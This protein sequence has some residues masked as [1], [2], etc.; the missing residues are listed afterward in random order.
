MRLAWRPRPDAVTLTP[1]SPTIVAMS[2]LAANDKR[3]ARSSRNTHGGE[4]AA[5]I[6]RL[7]VAG[8][9]PNF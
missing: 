3:M 2:T 6:V 8:E 9:I 5:P 4:V 7:A 1:T